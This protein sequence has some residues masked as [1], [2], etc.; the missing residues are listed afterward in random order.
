M[1]QLQETTFQT[2][3]IFQ[4]HQRTAGLSNNTVIIIEHNLDIYQTRRLDQL[5]PR[6]CRAKGGEILYAGPI[7]GIL[8][9]EDR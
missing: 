6:R 3:N 2:S 4:N 8:D 9:C 1:S 7:E 5:T